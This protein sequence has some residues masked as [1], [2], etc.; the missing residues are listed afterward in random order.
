MNTRPRLTRS[1][2]YWG[3]VVGSAASVGFG[4]WLTVDTLGTMTAGLDDGTATTAQVY[5]GQS[6]IVFGAAFVAAGL[7]G[8]VAALALAAARSLVSRPVEVVEAISWQEEE[9][10]IE[11]LADEPAAAETATATSEPADL[12]EAEVEPAPATR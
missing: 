11:A 7:V 3:L 10:D 9:P 5:G 1:I 12:P 2:P 8:L 6:W 4:V